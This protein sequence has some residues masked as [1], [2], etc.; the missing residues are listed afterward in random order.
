M[1]R[2]P[3]ANPDVSV[4]GFVLSE[5]KGMSPRSFQAKSSARTAR[6]WARF[7]GGSCAVLRRRR[8]AISIPDP[9][10]AQPC[11]QPDGPVR[12]SNL[13]RVCAARR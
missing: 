8:S 1:M 2:N 5:P 6:I 4:N 13:A 9:G 3:A 11:A 12:G 7:L 10:D